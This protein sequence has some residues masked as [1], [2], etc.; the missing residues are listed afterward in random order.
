MIYNDMLLGGWPTPLK[1]MKVRWDYDSQDMEKNMFQTTNQY[2]NVSRFGSASLHLNASPSFF[3]A[4]LLTLYEFYIAI[5][6]IWNAT[7]N[8]TIVGR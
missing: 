1:N 7:K 4:D 2:V 3:C 6:A 5:C 8:I